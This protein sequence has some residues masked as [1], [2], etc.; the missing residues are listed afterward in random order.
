M[1][2]DRTIELDETSEEAVISKSARV[3]EEISVSKTVD[4][5]TQTISDKLRR[6]EVEIEDD[7]KSDTAR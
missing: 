1:F 2:R 6:T 7:R 3:V 4:T 5:A